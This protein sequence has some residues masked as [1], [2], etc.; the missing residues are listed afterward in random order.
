MQYITCAFAFM[1]YAALCVINRWW[2][3]WWWW[4]KSAK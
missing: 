3:W 2:W 1:V 4:W